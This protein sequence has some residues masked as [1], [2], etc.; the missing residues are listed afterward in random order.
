MSK[1]LEYIDKRIQY[2]ENLAKPVEYKMPVAP[3]PIK[4]VI[5][6][7]AAFEEEIQTLNN[8]KQALIKAKEDNTT[9]KL[10]LDF[11]N[12]VSLQLHLTDIDEM[13]ERIEKLEKAWEVVKEKKV[14][15]SWLKVSDD[16][17]EYNV[18]S[19]NLSK[20]LTEEE[21]ELIKEMIE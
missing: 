19:E 16:L 2:V 1:E 11:V 4:V 14:E 5:N 6:H 8:I 9:L 18:D 20:P 12:E 15:I 3:Q 17:N 7:E 13:L 10:A 21:F